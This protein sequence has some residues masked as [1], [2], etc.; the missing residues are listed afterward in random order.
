M[1]Y[2]LRQQWSWSLT[3]TYMLYMYECISHGHPSGANSDFD[4]FRDKEIEQLKVM[5]KD[6]DGAKINFSSEV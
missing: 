1:S 5:Q 4:L 3:M 2:I 6:D